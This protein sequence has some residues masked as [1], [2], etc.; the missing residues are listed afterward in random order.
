MIRSAALS[1]ALLASSAPSVWADIVLP[2]GAAEQFAAMT[3]AGR[4]ALPIGAHDGDRVQTLPVEGTVIRRA[5]RIGGTGQSSFQI[6]LGLRQQLEDQGYDILF[7]CDQMTCGGYDF[8]FDTEVIGE[9]EMHVDLGDYQF[10]AAHVPGDSG[11]FASVLVSRSASAGYVQVIEVTPAGIA[12]SEVVSEAGE[13]ASE[14]AEPETPADPTPPE[15]IG[16]G[17]EQSGY[18]VLSD[19]QFETGSAALG[20]GDYASLAGLAAYLSSNPA[21]R[22]ALVGH[23][24]AQGSL[25]ANTAISEER[26]KSVRSRL[27]D[28]HGV[29]PD[30]LSAR[31]IGFLSPI[32]SNQTEEG[33]V[34]NRRVEA[35][36]VSV[37]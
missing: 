34:K 32:A 33:R 8:R 15:G 20:S 12:P 21:A 13:T 18:V 35:V 14:V 6:F 31:G 17:L 28:T 4:Y 22:V 27:I 19:L 11:A 37:D 29:N 36:L 24:D 30:Q 5:F 16:A 10:L 23:T 1:L 3:E 2:Q 26:A 25:A 7:Q 9:P